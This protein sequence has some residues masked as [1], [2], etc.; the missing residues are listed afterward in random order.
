MS[1]ALS[2]FRLISAKRP[3]L[4]WNLSQIGVRRP[5][6][7]SL[8]PMLKQDSTSPNRRQTYRR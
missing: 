7:G 8:V 3:V 6:K 4:S 5:T 1:P 2:K